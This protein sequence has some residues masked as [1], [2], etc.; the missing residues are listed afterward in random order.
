MAAPGIVVFI[1]F[2]TIASVL[3]VAIIKMPFVK[4]PELLAEP[5]WDKL[6][7]TGSVR[8]SSVVSGT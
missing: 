6:H 5:V 3:V 2:V 4:S 7:P 8:S 1:I